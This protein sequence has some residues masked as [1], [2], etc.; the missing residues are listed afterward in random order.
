MWSVATHATVSRRA[1]RAGGEGNLWRPWNPCRRCRCR[2]SSGPSQCLAT[3][4]RGGDAA[5]SWMVQQVNGGKGEAD[6]GHWMW[7]VATCAG[8]VVPGQPHQWPRGRRRRRRLRK[9]TSI[10]AGRPFWS[11]R[12][13]LRRHVTPLGFFTRPSFLAAQHCLLTSRRPE[14]A[15]VLTSPTPTMTT[16]T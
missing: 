9:S 15:L 5:G 10:C 1:G 12:L 4:A 14:E 8:T 13:L 11:S 6:V 7:C 2:G 16:H 3:A